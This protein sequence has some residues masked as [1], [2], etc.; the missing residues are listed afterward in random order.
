MTFETHDQSD[1]ET[2]PDQKKDHDKDKYNDKDIYNTNTEN[3][4]KSDHRDL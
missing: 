2:S 3:S 1:Y 4:S